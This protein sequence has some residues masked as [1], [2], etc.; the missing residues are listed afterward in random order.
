MLKSGWCQLPVVGSEKAGWEWDE[1]KVGGRGWCGI[2][3]RIETF[4]RLGNILCIWEED[5]CET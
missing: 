4:E 3:Q 2:D 1:V 5:P